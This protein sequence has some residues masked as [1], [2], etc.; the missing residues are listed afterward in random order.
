MGRLSRIILAALLALPAAAHAGYLQNGRFAEATNGIPTGWRL[1]AWAHDLS[2]VAWEPGKEGGVGTVR[3]VNREAND[4]RLCQSIAIAPGATYRVSARVKTEGVGAT[5]AGALIAIEPRIAD[6][7]DIKGTQDWQRIEVTAE[8]GGATTWD[9]CLRLGSYANLNTGTAWFSDV[10]VDQIG[11][12]APTEGGRR[13]PG[14]TLAPLIASIRQTPWMQTAMPLVGG[15]LLAF[16]L[17]IFRRR[18]P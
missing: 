10:Q 5:T 4:A 13:W 3:I 18:A 2:D 9:V 14:L 1:E 16:G 17:G 15:F 7:Q 6:S 11:G 12:P 8:S